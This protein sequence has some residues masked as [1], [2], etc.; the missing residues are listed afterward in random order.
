MATKRGV[1]EII[2]IVLVLLI[3]VS[4]ASAFYF[5]Y[6]RV[7]TQAQGSAEASTKV[8]VSNLNRGIKI[9]ST[10]YNL[11]TNLSSVQVKNSGASSLK[12]GDG[13]RLINHQTLNLIKIKLV[14]NI[15]S[16]VA[17]HSARRDNS[18]GRLIFLYIPYL[19]GTRMGAKQKTVF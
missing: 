12:I 11:L 7:Q 3:L 16:F 19:H 17:E 10:D 9:V 1:E 8:F 18:Q 5:W 14:R 6:G 4:V 2:S 15:G 13:S